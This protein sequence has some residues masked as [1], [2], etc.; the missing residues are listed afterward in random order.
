MSSQGDE[1]F[2]ELI[3][4]MS[5]QPTAIPA[6]TPDA[7]AFRAFL[8]KRFQRFELAWEAMD[9]HGRGALGFDAFVSACRRTEF[10]GCLRGV[11]DELAGAAGVVTLASLDPG[12][13]AALAALRASR[14]AS[15]AEGEAGRAAQSLYSL[16]K[17]GF[18][19]DKDRLA[20][21]TWS[22][23]EWKLRLQRFTAEGSPSDSRAFRGAMVKKFGS[24][25]DAFT[26]ADKN[27][28]GRMQFYEFVQMCRHVNFSG[29]LRRIFDELSGG[30]E[31]LV[32]EVLFNRADKEAA[33]ERERNRPRTPKGLQGAALALS[34]AQRLFP[35]PA[36]V[37][38]QAANTQRAALLRWE[39][40]AQ[41]AEGA[42]GRAADQL[43][44]A[45]PSRL[46][47]W[48]AEWE[49]EAQGAEGAAG[50]AAIPAELD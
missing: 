34:L 14:P 33:E 46:R 16:A 25:E 28:D 44:L 31:E 36:P 19:A 49:A 32:I 24:L 15:V 47:R 10:G 23:V 26:A 38:L 9:P 22:E 2:A 43:F 42:A 45:A 6:S 1:T 18:A 48:E 4:L 13:P 35:S 37:A 27:A 8:L 41:D 29:N 30:R 39:A 17:A 50:R 3:E 40:E 21:S 7:R 5:S 20:A 11:F 12:A